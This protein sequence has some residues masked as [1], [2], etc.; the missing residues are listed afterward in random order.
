M[1]YATRA[2]SCVLLIRRV[3]LLQRVRAAAEAVIAARVGAGARRHRLRRHR[4]R[5]LRLG[6]DQ[7]GQSARRHSAFAVVTWRRLEAI[8]RGLRALQ[9]RQFQQARAAA[10]SRH[11]LERS[12]Q[13]AEVE[14]ALDVGRERA[15]GVVGEQ[16]SQALAVGELDGLVLRGEVGPG[17]VRHD[18]RRLQVQELVTRFVDLICGTSK[19]KSG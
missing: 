8:R 19:L 14:V 17:D 15:L 18:Q 6:G 5:A 1:T 4:R 9:M 11:L 7:Q 3:E 16:R 10:A 13:R 2:G 12:E